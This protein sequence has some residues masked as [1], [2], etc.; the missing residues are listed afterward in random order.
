M[1]EIPMP[2]PLTSARLQGLNKFLEAI[3]GQPRRL[4]DILRSQH[5]TDDEV[6]ILKKE[7]LNAYLAAFIAGLQAILEE[8]EDQRLKGIITCRY[9]LDNGQRMIFQHIGDIY[10]VSR[11]RIRQLHN[12]AV[13]KLR[14]PKKKERLERLASNIASTIL[15]EHGHLTFRQR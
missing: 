11:E 15:Y 7:H 1:V 3:Y 14:N 5:F 2:D 10:G 13:R 8:M 6:T 12:K 9:G 4:S